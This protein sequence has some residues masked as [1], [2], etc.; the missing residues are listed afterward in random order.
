MSG[1]SARGEGAVVAGGG[2]V[3]GAAGCEEQ[4]A[5]EAVE[6]GVEERL[7]R[8]CGDGEPCRDR[9]LRLGELAR[10]LLRPG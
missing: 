4:V 3:G 1:N 7:A 9:A 8:L 2:L 5:V 10:A 6:V